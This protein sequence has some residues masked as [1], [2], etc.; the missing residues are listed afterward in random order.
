MMNYGW[1]PMMG[2]WGG[3]G[4]GLWG[5]LALLTW[6]VWLAVGILL[7]IWLWKRIKQ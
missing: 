2:A 1:G 7:V 5:L 3:V 4:A 6:L